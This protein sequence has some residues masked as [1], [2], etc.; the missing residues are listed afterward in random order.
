[1]STSKDLVSPRTAPLATP[2]DLEPEAVKN[3]T[4][5]LNALLADTFSLYLKTKNFHWHISGPHFRDYHLL[6]DE[7]GEQIFA[8]TDDIA[9]RV[10]KI[11]GT[12]IRSIGHIARLQRLNDNDAEYVEAA[13]MLSELREDNKA[14]VLSMRAVHD[15]CDE[16]GDVATASLLENWIDEAQRRIWFLFEATR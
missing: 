11:G 1:M 3:I 9:E 10:R 2:T 4:G 13:D 7:Q 8:T 12:T 5:A 6:L 16:A 14:L 15:L